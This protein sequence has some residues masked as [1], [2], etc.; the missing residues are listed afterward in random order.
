MDVLKYIFSDI[1]TLKKK[2]S[3]VELAAKDLQ[4]HKLAITIVK[5]MKMSAIII[6]LIAIK[7]SYLHCE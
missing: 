4:H 2:I 1:Y 7:V 6:V 5:G 3:Y